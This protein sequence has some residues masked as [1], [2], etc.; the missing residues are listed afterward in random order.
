MDPTHEL[1]G[2]VGGFSLPASGAGAA[3][4]AEGTLSIE[5]VRQ[6]LLALSSSPELREAAV[7]EL[8]VDLAR[9]ADAI[10][11]VAK[12]ITAS[13]ERMTATLLEVR[14][15][16]ERLADLAGRHEAAFKGDL[17]VRAAQL[18]RREAV[19]ALSAELIKLQQLVLLQRPARTSWRAIA[20][21][22]ALTAAVTALCMAQLVIGFHH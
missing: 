13:D 21:A 5:G 10:Q 11:N 2:R 3:R 8:V 18:A 20:T 7:A 6:T 14:E 19:E 15:A 22:V 17:A 16:G 4:P 1:P 12:L 9:T